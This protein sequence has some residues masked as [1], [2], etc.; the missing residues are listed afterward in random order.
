MRRAW[1][2]ATDYSLL[3]VAGAVIALIWANIDPDAYHAVV[4]WPILRDSPVGYATYG[5]DGAV[6]TRTLTFHSLVND[7]LMAFFFAIA[8]KEVWEALVLREGSLRGGRAVVPLM[9]AAG[10][11]LGPVAVYL[12]LAALLGSTT[13]DAL[14]QGWAVPTATDIAFSYLV[15]RVIWGAGHPAVNFLMLLAIADDAAGLV[16]IAVFYPKGAI[17]PEWLLL[18]VGAALAVYLLANRLPRWLD[19]DDPARPRA[20]WVRARLSV[21]PYLAAGCASWY[22]FQ[23]AGIHPA[24]GL[25]PIIPA[26]PHA[27][28]DF[29]LFADDDRPDLLNHAEHLLKA[30]VEGVLFLFGLLNAGVVLTAAG[31]PTWLV[32]AGLLI[33]KPAGIL[34]AGWLGARGLRLGLPEGMGMRDVLV[35]GF[36][37]S[38]GFTV[39]LFVASV[40]FAPDLTLAGLP[41]QDA[42]KLGALLS[43]LGGP[44]AWAVARAAGVG[45]RA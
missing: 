21:W 13:F 35:V 28:R 43:I 17:L 10:G 40:A 16:I 8:A 2:F 4:E 9:S 32:L 25:L 14:A 7:V 20:T 38:I 45:R 27:D 26:I 31:A 5:A 18:S 42:A 15:A 34:A 37:A 1:T 30:P 29:G 19:G 22:G 6:E 41:V 23:Q 24:L 12:G 33:G 44:I 11:M 36:V 3:M 39:A